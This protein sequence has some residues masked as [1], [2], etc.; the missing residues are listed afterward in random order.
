MLEPV[1]AEIT[2]GRPIAAVNILDQDG[3]R[4]GKTLPV[5]K[6]SFTID[7]AREKTIYYEVV[8]E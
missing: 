1:K 6:N 3:Q 2:C 7:S 4:S 8:F 5:E